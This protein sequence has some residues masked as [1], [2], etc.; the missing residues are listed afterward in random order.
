MEEPG[1]GK[2]FKMAVYLKRNFLPGDLKKTC[3]S[4]VE[5]PILKLGLPNFR[6]SPYF[7]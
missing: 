3:F 2:G 1:T 4:V 7:S 6:W 5:R